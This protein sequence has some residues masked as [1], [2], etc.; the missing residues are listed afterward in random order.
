MHTA[1]PTRNPPC[2]LALNVSKLRE[3]GRA[4]DITTDAELAR[5]IGVDPTTLYRIT[6][7]RVSPSGTF[8]A[9]VKVAFPS[10]SLDALFTAQLPTGLVA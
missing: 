2:T 9:Q 1:S 10:A 8:V 6:T 4:H 3:L 7:G 5:T